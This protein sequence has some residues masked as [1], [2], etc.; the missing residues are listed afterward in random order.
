MDQHPSDPAFEVKR[1]QRCMND[2]VSVLA[3]PSVWC[4]NEPSRVVEIL[5]DALLGMLNL[6]FLYARVKTSSHEAPIELL[7]TAEPD[8]GS[9]NGDEIRQAL[10]RR[11]REGAPRWIVEAPIKLG[12]ENVS[13]FP[14]Q[15][16]VE[17]ELGLL[18]AGSRR[19]AFPEQTERLILSVAANQAAIELQQGLLLI[20]Q[21]RVAIE[22]D[23]RVSQR[24]AELA[25]ANEA[26]R[27]SETNLRQIVDSI[28]GLVCTMDATGEIE[29]LNLPLL[30]YFGKTPG[31][32]KGWKM[33][34]AVHPEDLPQVVEAFTYSVTTGTPTSLNIVADGPTVS[35][36]GS[37]F[38]PFQY[39][40]QT[41]VSPA[42]MSC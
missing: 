25:T 36:D 3:L 1:L 42:G 39:E 18:V 27:A 8:G 40:T 29:Q 33:T 19:M 31:E 34:D 16:G 23:H 9:H 4:G 6:D 5:L 14:M 12:E 32:L 13:V 7:R 24:T 38:A 21:K 41:V 28:P 17:G 2:L 11:F 26:L 30:E 22:L 35:I 20:E 37:K 15:M 10:H